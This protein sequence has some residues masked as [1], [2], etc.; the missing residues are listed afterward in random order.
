MTAVELV[1]IECCV[2][3]VGSA[4]EVYDLDLS[5]LRAIIC[6]AL[7]RDRTNAPCASLR[8]LT[9]TRVVFLCATARQPLRSPSLLDLP[10][11]TRATASDATVT[12]TQLCKSWSMPTDR[13][14]SCEFGAD[15]RVSS[16]DRQQNVTRRHTR[17]PPTRP[18]SFRLKPSP[19]LIYK[20]NFST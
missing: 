13:E 9:H 8:V 5:T 12:F 10:L 16:T 19:G 18:K 6:S 2:T 3:F 1:I 11:K 4:A 7:A 17:T 20:A 14:F 15:P